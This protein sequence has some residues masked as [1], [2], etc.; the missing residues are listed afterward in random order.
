MKNTNSINFPK[1]PLRGLGANLNEQMKKI[2][3]VAAAVVVALSASAK[4]APKEQPVLLNSQ[5]DSVSYAIG[6]S[7]GN[8][9]RGN[10]ESTFEGK[11]NIDL[12]LKGMK[13][14]LNNDTT[15]LL[16]REEAN[17]II[18]SYMMAVFAEKEKA[19]KETGQ[20]FL[21]ENAKRPEVKTTASGLQY[22][23]IKKGAGTEHPL[24]TSTVKVDY[25]G[26]LIDGTVFDSSIQRGEPIEFALNRVIPGWT[27]GVQLMNEG[28][29]FKL[30]IPSELGYGA[31]PAG[32]IPP[33]STLIFEVRLLEIK[34]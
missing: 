8:D 21:E 34:K 26:T 33:H 13:Q 17:K 24:A 9:L 31:Q 12:L 16:S 1:S 4:K 6:V 5:T 10:L 28:D 30:Y 20:K 14:G 2:L 32:T 18:E 7:V 15:A 11:Q 23:V 19:T 27:E 29:I 3:F 22:E 25:E